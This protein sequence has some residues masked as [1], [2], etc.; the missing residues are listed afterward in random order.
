MAASSLWALGVHAGVDVAVTASHVLLWPH[1][2]AGPPAA[3]GANVAAATAQPRTL[4]RRRTGE[5]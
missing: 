1:V 5:N 2:A 4:E 3:A